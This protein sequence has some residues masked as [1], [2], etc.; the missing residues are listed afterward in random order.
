MAVFT[1][2]T[3]FVNGNTADGGEINTEIVNL[4]T[5][6]N[7]I[8]NAQ[9]SSSAA[10][11]LAKLADG[12]LP[13]GVT[14]ASANITDDTIVNAD[15]NS[16]AAIALSKLATGALPAA[17]TV[18]SANITNDTIVDA[19]INSAAA[20]TNT[21]V[22]T[23]VLNSATITANINAAASNS[24]TIVDITGLECTPTLPSGRVCKIIADVRLYNQSAGD[25]LSLYIYEGVTQYQK[26][27]ALSGAANGTVS[28]H[29]VK[30]ITGD[31]IAHTVKL[32]MSTASGTGGIN[33]EAGATYPATIMV[34]LI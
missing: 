16:A 1:Q 2:T 12:A 28:L 11:A 25:Y 10:I 6:V 20:I 7:N 17:I 21:K 22:A 19:D 24:G 23:G 4:G 30:Y 8:V 3:T 29:A 9:I 31:G 32:C 27:T 26:A 13:A 33:C 5:S 34:E 15:I 18:A 14:V